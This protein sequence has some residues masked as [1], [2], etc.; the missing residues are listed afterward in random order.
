D[1]G[2][3][4]VGLA[5]PIPGLFDVEMSTASV[6]ES[7]LARVAS[8]GLRA[9]LVP[10][11]SDVDTPADLARLRAELA[12]PAVAALAPRTAA[13]LSKG[14]PA[15][16]RGRACPARSSIRFERP[17]LPIETLRRRRSGALQRRRRSEGRASARPSVPVG[18]AW[19]S[20]SR[21]RRRGSAAL[22]RS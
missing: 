6:L 17:V 2:Y 4:L 7:S 14:G 16:P 1:G 15:N 12:D 20:R 18:D 8:S 13:F 21:P 22:R 9:E 5:R 10:S 3:H 11:W 19:H